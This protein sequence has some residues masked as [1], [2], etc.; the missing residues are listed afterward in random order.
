M[1][2][3][4]LQSGSN[5]NCFYVETSGVRLLFDAGICG[6]Q[7]EGRLKAAGK[8][9]RDVDALIISH[10]HADHV[11]HAGVLQR[12]FGIPLYITPRTLAMAE[13]RHRLG[14]LREVHC[15]SAGATLRVG[16]V[17]IHSIPTPHDGADGSVFIVDSGKRR[18]G[19]LTDIGH[20]FPELIT[21]VSSLDGIFLESNYDPEMLEHGQYPAFLKR[22]IRG[23]GGH[24]SNA[25]SAELLCWGGRLQWACLAHLS[26][27]NNDPSLALKTHRKV[28]GNKL[29]LH[30]A[31]RYK[32][33]GIFRL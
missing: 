23:E 3:I 16:S 7:A 5:G 33:T 24:L 26:Q 31:G 15:F 25:E 19:I 29:P 4:S 22:R 14:K 17:S 2:A 30:I 27:D 8:D 18:L 20:I 10:D 21:A 28:L 1:Q 9:I 32:P 11:K 13:S 6:S 12:K